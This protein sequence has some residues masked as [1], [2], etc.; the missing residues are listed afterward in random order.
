MLPGFGRGAGERGVDAAAAGGHA[1]LD[2]VGL[3]RAQNLQKTGV[4]MRFAADQR[5]FRDREL[6]ELFHESEAFFGGELFGAR[7]AR[8]GAAV[9]AREIASQRELPDGDARP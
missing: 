7:L 6:S 9:N 2:P 3:E 1:D 5:H 4:K 8:P